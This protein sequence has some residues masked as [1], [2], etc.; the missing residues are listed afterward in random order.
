M[1]IL[2]FSFFLGSSHP[3]NVLACES[4]AAGHE[5]P[6]WK[7][8]EDSRIFH[9]FFFLL[10]LFSVIPG[11]QSEEWS[12]IGWRDEDAEG[13]NFDASMPSIGLIMADEHLNPMPNGESI[14]IHSGISNWEFIT[15]TLFYSF[16]GKSEKK[17][18]K[19]RLQTA[20][21]ALSSLLSFYL[22][23]YY[24]PSIAWITYPLTTWTWFSIIMDHLP[25]PHHL[26]S[27]EFM[28]ERHV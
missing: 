4:W 27:A 21:F 19:D 5:L 24:T 16:P 8:D 6:Y 10:F 15:S 11:D 18:L 17:V 14:D 26:Q 13:D 25:K 23:F 12:K 9:G 1:I 20:S 3:I 22:S 2:T 7:R 28:L